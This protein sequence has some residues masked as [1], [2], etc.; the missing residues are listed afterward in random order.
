MSTKPESAKLT[1]LKSE[2]IS[3]IKQL[4]NKPPVDGGGA[5][6]GAGAGGGAGVG[7]GAG[8]LERGM[9]GPK[10]GGK[11][12]FDDLIIFLNGAP[13][14]PN[15]KPKLK[16][17]YEFINDIPETPTGSAPAGSS[18]AGSAPAGSDPVKIDTQ[19][20]DSTDV[21]VKIKSIANKLNDTIQQFRNIYENNGKEIEKVSSFDEKVAKVREIVKNFETFLNVTFDTAGIEAALEKDEF[22]QLASFKL[23]AV[24]I[25]AAEDKVNTLRGNVPS[26]QAKAK[27]L[28]KKK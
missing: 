16:K 7:A 14:D 4:I 1:L 23:Q 2:S 9:S 8:G 3:L 10:I 12:N 15:I 13:I 5:G 19:I 18:P 21:T 27:S 25:K 17:V 24:L 22:T 20:P 6:A 11:G 28:S 26:G